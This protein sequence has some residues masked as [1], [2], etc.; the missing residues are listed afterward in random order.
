MREREREKE[1]RTKEPHTHMT[2]VVRPK[3]QKNQNS[4]NLKQ[5]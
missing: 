1:Q 3:I 2:H 4:P 5:V